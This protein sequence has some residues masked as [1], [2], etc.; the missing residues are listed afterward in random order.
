M[1]ICSNEKEPKLIVLKCFKRSPGVKKSINKKNQE[2][3]K[4]TDPAA[5]APATNDEVVETSA[6]KYGNAKTRFRL[7]EQIS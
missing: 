6:K 4:E 5:A 2:Q 7:K 1:N 3:K